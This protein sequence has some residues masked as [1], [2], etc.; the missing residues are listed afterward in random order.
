[1]FRLFRREFIRDLVAAATS[2]AMSLMPRHRS[3]SVSR[4][5]EAMRRKQTMTFL[6]SIRESRVFLA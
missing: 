6:F 5:N 2:L 4:R 1:M 3:S